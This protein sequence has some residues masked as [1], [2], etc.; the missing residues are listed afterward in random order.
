[1][2]KHKDLQGRVSF[3]PNRSISVDRTDF[4]ANKFTNQLRV[5]YYYY[6]YFSILGV[7]ELA[8]RVRILH[9]ATM[10]LLPFLLVNGEARKCYLSKF[11]F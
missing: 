11:A 8:S 4:Q 9:Q 6:Y 7:G 3:G 10:T 5:N 1:M 2:Y